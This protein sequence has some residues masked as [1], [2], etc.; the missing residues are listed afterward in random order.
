MIQRHQFPPK[1]RSRYS[2][3]RVCDVI[4]GIRHIIPFISCPVGLCASVANLRGN[5]PRR[6][7][8]S[9]FDFS[10]T[11]PRC[12]SSDASKKK[13]LAHKP[14]KRPAL[15]LN[16]NNLSISDRISVI[17]RAQLFQYQKQATQA[18]R[19]FLNCLPDFA[20]ILGAWS[21]KPGSC[22]EGGTILFFSI[23]RLSFG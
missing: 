21:Y 10:C 8:P 15:S 9:V 17:F 6:A 12:K 14:T 11:S 7:P 4:M 13:K 23:A 2:T 18:E 1:W 16:D 19:Q 5:G 3:M 22:T 20:A